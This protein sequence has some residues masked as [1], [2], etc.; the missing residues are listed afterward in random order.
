[1]TDR[2]QRANWVSVVQIADETKALA[3]ALVELA[4]ELE[5]GPSGWRTEILL[6]QAFDRWT[7][8][9][10]PAHHLMMSTRAAAIALFYSGPIERKADIVDRV[11]A[12]SQAMLA[13][14]EQR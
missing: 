6:E 9:R 3:V 4:D 1:M 5:L 11:R 10:S 14:A 8:A 2:H 12:T 13:A 7:A